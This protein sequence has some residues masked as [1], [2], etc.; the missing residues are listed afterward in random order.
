MSMIVKVHKS[1]ARM[2]RQK[3]AALI[4]AMVLLLV[5]TLLA[6]AGMNTA[7]LEFAMAGNQQFR[8]RAF[9]AA[10]TG[11]HTGFVQADVQTI[12][13]WTEN[14]AATLNAGNSYRAAVAPILNAAG[15]EILTH[16]LTGWSNKVTGTHFSVVS[17]GVS[18]RNSTATHVQEFYIVGP[19]PAPGAVGGGAGGAPPPPSLQ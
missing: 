2:R 5:L 13:T 14:F 6:V 19:A 10:E 9:E 16:Q 3:G 4:I 8:S 11:L 1:P 17:T 15:T 7:S 18:G 12:P